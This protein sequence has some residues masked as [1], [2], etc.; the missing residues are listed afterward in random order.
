M[1]SVVLA[2]HN[3]AKN[4][5]RCLAA[6]KDWADEIIVIDGESTD[7]TTT[8]AKQLGAKIFTT[9]NK[10]NFHINKQIAMDKAKG[11]LVLQLDA[12]EVV[13]DQ[14]RQ[15]IVDIHQRILRKEV[16]A[17]A[18]WVKRKNL[19]FGR[20]LTKGGQYPDPVIRLYQKGKA[21]LPQKDVH[22]QMTVDGEVDWAE[23]HLLHYSNPTFAD[24]L[25]KFN[26]YTSFAAERLFEQKLQP[27]F[28]ME[29]QYFTWKPFAMFF[30]LY[31]RH[32]GLV[33]GTAGFLF[34]VCSGLHYPV[35]YLK[36][37]E[38]YAQNH[39]ST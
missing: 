6:V 36:F 33:D 34:A 19:F 7:E 37:C 25:R 14:L 15:F 4:I 26:T 16:L 10:A 13:D 27:S 12:D 18:W 31:I 23:G 21:R 17:S 20:F 30:S 2:T 1:I 28:G 11:D 38:R 35:T 29:L 39:R 22:E 8:L 5:E 3:E 32:R 24:Y 9:T